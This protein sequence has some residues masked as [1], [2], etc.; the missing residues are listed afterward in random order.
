MQ[1][2]AFIIDIALTITYDPEEFLKRC[3]PSAKFV[4]RQRDQNRVAHV[5]PF[6]G[7][8]KLSD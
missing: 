4:P 1:Q 6:F 3:N 7:Q 2:L 5:N 8:Q